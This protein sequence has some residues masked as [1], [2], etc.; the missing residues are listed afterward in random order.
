MGGIGKRQRRAYLFVSVSPSVSVFLPF[1]PP[2]PTVERAEDGRS[3]SFVRRGVEEAGA[4]KDGADI[5]GRYGGHGRRHQEP[6]R[7]HD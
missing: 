6:T 5:G 7:L 3:W 1:S 2:L 4:A